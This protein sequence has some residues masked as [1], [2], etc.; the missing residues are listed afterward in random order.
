MKRML[1]LLLLATVLLSL[2]AWAELRVVACEPE[3]A[4]LASAIGGDDITADSATPGLQDV[5]H[6]PARP[7]LIA[8][9]RRADLLVCTGAGLEA[10]WLPV[11]LRQAG[12]AKVQPGQPGFLEAAE[13]VEMLEVPV[14]VDRSQG[15]VHPYGNPHIQTDPRNIPPVAAALLERLVLLD[16]DGAEGYRARHAGFSDQWGTALEDWSARGAELEGMAIVTHHKSWIYLVNWLGLDEV[17]TLE[18]KPGIE[19]SAGHLARLLTSI[20]GRDVR[21]IIRTSY[22]SARASDWLSARIDAPAV[23]LPHT[24]GSVDGTDDLFSLYEI[25]LTTLERGSR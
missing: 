2:P 23:V 8:R 12:N 11:L 4:A 22:Q 1:Q 13:Y 24:V 9:V 25:M 3:W 10:G 20:E 7:S 21:L 14:S 6:I 5:H 16:P 19:P 17:A 15:D 18:P